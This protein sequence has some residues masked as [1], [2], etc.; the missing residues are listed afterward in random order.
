MFFFQALPL[1]YNSKRKP[2]IMIIKSLKK[3]IL[4]QTQVDFA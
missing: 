3:V 1:G 4:L 2:I